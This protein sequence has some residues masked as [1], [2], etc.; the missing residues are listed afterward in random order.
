MKNCYY[1]LLTVLFGLLGLTAQ[2]KTASITVTPGSSARIEVYSSDAGGK[3]LFMNL[4]AGEHTLTIN[5]GRTYSIYANE[6][7]VLTEVLRADGYNLKT[8]P[9]FKGRDYV[10]VSTYNLDS[11]YTITTIPESEIE[12]IDFTLN[13]TEVPDELICM[14]ATDRKSVV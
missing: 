11:K 7:H 12:H 3:I 1:L 10:E 8:D 2:A 6:G 5:D 4:P 14:L 9:M 13:I